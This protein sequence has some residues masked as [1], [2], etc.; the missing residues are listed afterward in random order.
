MV[1]IEA[2]EI[3]GIYGKEFSDPPNGGTSKVEKVDLLDEFT[4]PKT[5]RVFSVAVA[6]RCGWVGVG[7]GSGCV[8]IW[9]FGI[10][11]STFHLGISLKKT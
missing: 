3:H 6:V 11:E 9:G 1:N 5:G 4:H 7:L 2:Q 10:W 8:Q